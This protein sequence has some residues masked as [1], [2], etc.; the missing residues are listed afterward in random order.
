MKAVRCSDGSVY[1][2]AL[3]NWHWDVLDI[4]KSH[5]WCGESELEDEAH[6]LHLKRMHE[7][8]TAFQAILWKIIEWDFERFREIEDGHSNQNR[9]TAKIGHPFPIYL[10]NQVQAPFGVAFDDL[11]AEAAKQ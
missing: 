1:P 9:E 10:R 3:P 7:S 5:D 8:D 11:Q 2:T 4:L 6:H